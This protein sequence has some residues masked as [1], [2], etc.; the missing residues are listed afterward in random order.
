M[1]EEIIEFV[2]EETLNIADEGNDVAFR[3]QSNLA[4]DEAKANGKSSTESPSTGSTESRQLIIPPLS[5][6][7]HTF[8]TRKVYPTNSTTE[9]SDQEV[10]LVMVTDPEDNTLRSDF[11]QVWNH[12]L[13]MIKGDLMF[14]LATPQV[15]TVQA[16]IRKEAEEYGDI[17]QLNTI[18]SGQARYLKTLAAMLWTTQHC[19]HVKFF[20]RMNVDVLVQVESLRS[21][22]QRSI[23]NNH[24]QVTSAT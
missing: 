1:D 15:P 24:H 11:R 18:S 16:T 9:E 2:E 17:L 3:H 19:P 23:T 12:Y 7:P 20:I 6:Q 4:K 5:L 14:V 21:V 10:L 22:L 13:P 8:C